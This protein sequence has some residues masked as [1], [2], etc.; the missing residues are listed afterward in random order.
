VGVILGLVY[1]VLIGGY[2]LM[3]NNENPAMGGVV[4]VSVFIAISIG[5]IFGSA[6]PV[7]LSRLGVD[8]AVATGPFVT[9]AVDL[10][11]I[12]VYFSVASVLL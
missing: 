8:P 6:L 4:L 10:F 11:G 3:S 7:V 9:S 5:A 2:A 12:F 1:G